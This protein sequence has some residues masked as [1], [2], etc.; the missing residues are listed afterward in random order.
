MTPW[1]TVYFT[2]ITSTIV[3][4]R[5]HIMFVPDVFASSGGVSPVSVCSR[6]AEEFHSDTALFLLTED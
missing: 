1:F 3:H 5:I 2:S 4:R 6:T